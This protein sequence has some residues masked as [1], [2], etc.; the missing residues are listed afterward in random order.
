MKFQ[1]L[2]NTTIFVN[3]RSLATTYNT[4]ILSNGKVEATD[5]VTQ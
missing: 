1:P 4:R 2:A 5:T 3:A